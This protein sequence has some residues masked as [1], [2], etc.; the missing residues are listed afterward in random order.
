[1]EGFFKIYWTNSQRTLYNYSL[2]VE[3]LLSLT[4][5]YSQTAAIFLE[6]F[7]ACI[8]FSLLVTWIVLNKNCLLNVN[9]LFQ[10][11]AMSFVQIKLELWQRMKWLLPIFLLLMGSML[12]YVVWHLDLNLPFYFVVCIS[13]NMLD[14]TTG[15][16]SVKKA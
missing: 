7:S 5:F 11:V 16:A 3:N 9:L 1:M 8:L 12:R 6:I 4:C 13:W 2:L 15:K 14:Y 10:A